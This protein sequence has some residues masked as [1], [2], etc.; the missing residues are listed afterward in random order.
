[1]SLLIYND[2]NK[3]IPRDK[4]V[5]E[6]GPLDRPFLTKD[7]YNVFFA[8]INSTENVKLSLKKINHS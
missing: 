1:M 7:K 6:I 8:D 5:M 3:Y 4:P 2:T